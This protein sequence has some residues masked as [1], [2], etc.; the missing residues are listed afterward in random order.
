M[1][2]FIIILLLFNTTRYASSCSD[3][4]YTEKQKAEILKLLDRERVAHFNR[5]AAMFLSG[6]SYSMISV[7]KG[8]IDFT[9]PALLRPRFE[10]YF[11][12]TSFIKWDD[13][14]P[15]VIRFSDDG[16]LAYAV[17]QKEVIT[18]T[19][20]SSGKTIT[21]TAVFAW[22][23]VYRKYKDEWQIECNISTSK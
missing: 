20:D 8:R 9:P 17:V 2:K 1:N 13:I 12:S 18:N 6:F 3:T 23:S 21:D 7:N 5:D 4:N 19:K 16:T 14:T 22:A 10:N 15:P 11:G